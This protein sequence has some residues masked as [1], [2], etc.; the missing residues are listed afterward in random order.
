MSKRTFFY[1]DPAAALWMVKAYRMKLLA[2][3]GAPLFI[4]AQPEA[5]GSEQRA[6][7]KKCFAQAARS[8]PLGQPLDWETNPHPAEW[9]LDGQK[10][11]FN[12]QM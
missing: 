8:L 4:S 9:L 5:T 7:I 3:S 1:T 11:H 12:W 2:G 10:T 6:F